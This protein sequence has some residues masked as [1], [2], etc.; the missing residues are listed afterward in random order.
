MQNVHR[1]GEANDHLKSHAPRPSPPPSPRNTDEREN[2]LHVSERSA[3]VNDRLNQRPAR[4]HLVLVN[5][6]RHP[7]IA[8][9]FDLCAKTRQHRVRFLHALERNVRIRIARAEKHG[10]A[11]SEPAYSRGVPGGPINPPVRAK[12]AP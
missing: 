8:A 1:S 10:R 4:V 12:T 11:S 9:D 6:V 3:P 2:G 7:E 5:R